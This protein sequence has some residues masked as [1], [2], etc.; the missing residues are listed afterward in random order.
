MDTA[1]VKSNCHFCDKQG[2]LTCG[3]CID[4]YQLIQKNERPQRV[5]RRL[6][7]ERRIAERTSPH[8]RVAAPRGA[9]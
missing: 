5:A 3:A 1:P 7:A 9:R 6:L 8:K 4:C 2:Y